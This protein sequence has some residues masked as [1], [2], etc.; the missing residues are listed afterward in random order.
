[1]GSG[2]E[3]TVNGGRQALGR[4]TVYQLNEADEIQARAPGQLPDGAKDKGTFQP[5]IDISLGTRWGIVW[6]INF[7]VKEKGQLLRLTP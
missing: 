5:L 4:V 7:R 3:R 2:G 1:M 6:E